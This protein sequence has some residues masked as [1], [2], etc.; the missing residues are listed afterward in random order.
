MLYCTLLN[1]FIIV[2]IKNGSYI[3]HHI[4]KTDLLAHPVPLPYQTNDF[5]AMN[6]FSDT[7]SKLDLKS[8]VSYGK[9]K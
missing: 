9:K 1:V 2:H 7:A 6:V 8:E 5:I 3:H 4:C